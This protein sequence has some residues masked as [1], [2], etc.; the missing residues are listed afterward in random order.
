MDLFSRSFHAQSSQAQ[1]TKTLISQLQ[2][3]N[4]NIW[5]VAF[6]ILILWLYMQNF[7]SVASILREPFEVTNRQTHG[8][9]KKI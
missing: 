5:L 4:S 9:G 6:K 3:K 7:S 1:E 2:D 8:H